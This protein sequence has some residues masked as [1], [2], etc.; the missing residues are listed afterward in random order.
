MILA[1]ELG[2]N[3]FLQARDIEEVMLAQTSTQVVLKDAAEDLHLL[4]GD[5]IVRQ[6]RF[7]NMTTEDRL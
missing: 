6:E 1:S 4:E 5:Q 3:I 7:N 2:K